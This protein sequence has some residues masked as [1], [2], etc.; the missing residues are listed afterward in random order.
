[1]PSP[2]KF[3][4]ALQ[5][6]LEDPLSSYAEELDADGI[7]ERA[8]R[9]HANTAIVLARDARGRVFYDGWKALP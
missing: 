9:V 6:N 2:P 5:I 8:G 7:A 1:M 3:I 4:R